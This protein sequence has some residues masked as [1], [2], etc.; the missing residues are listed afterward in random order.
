MS[1]SGADHPARFPPALGIFFLPR[2]G[3]PRAMSTET[4]NRADRRNRSTP[5]TF[6]CRSYPRCGAMLCY[7]GSRCGGKQ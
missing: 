2:E 1:A 3:P 6:S 7:R 5:P 4:I